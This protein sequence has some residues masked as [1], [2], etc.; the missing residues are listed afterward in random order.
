MDRT[1]K[2]YPGTDEIANQ[3]QGQ[4]PHSY[5]YLQHESSEAYIGGYFCRNCLDK[6]SNHHSRDKDCH[7]DWKPKPE[8]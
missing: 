8:A 4:N 2:K 5:T 7:K 1:F 3:Q 6:V